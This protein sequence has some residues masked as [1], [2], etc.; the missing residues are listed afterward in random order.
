MLPSVRRRTKLLAPVAAVAPVLLTALPAHA[1]TT[2]VALWHMNSSPMVDATGHQANGTLTDVSVVSGGIAGSKA[3]SFTGSDSHVTVPNSATLNPGTSDFSYTMHLNFS[4]V[5]SKTVGDY[6]IIRKGLAGTSGGEWK[7]EI[8]P[9]TTTGAGNPFCLFKDSAGHTD[10]V[11]GNQ[12]LADGAWHTVTC[13]KTSTTDSL[14]VDGSTKSS[15]PSTPLG[16][17]SNTAPVVIGQ[18]WGGGDQYRGLLDE[19]SVTLGAASSGGVDTTPPTVTAKS[20]AAGSTGVSTATAVTARF[21]EAVQNVTGTTVKLK[22]S[23]TSTAVPAT[24]AY[25]SATDTATL[26]PKAA[27]NA[28]TKYT[29]TLTAG[30]KDLAGNA[31]KSLSWS[32]TTGSGT[33]TASGPTLTSRSPADGATGISRWTNVVATFD[34]PVRNVG[35]GTFTLAP[36]AGGPA[37]AAAYSTN[38]AKT[39]WV[40]NPSAGLAS[41]TRYTVTLVGGSS[42]ITDL[43]GNPLKS[44]TWSFT[45]G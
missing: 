17:I 40:L 23:G 5:P 36:A 14:T 4:V 12:D 9:N 37:V 6:D 34:E 33:T 15:T 27:L 32:F 29:A 39:R 8:L 10:T 11:R 30:I 16:S 44:T 13:T 38:S 1:A 43:Y 31:L 25:D 24:V 18:K 21:S 26:Q 22:V 20:P 7:M 19:A 42:G 35:S 3:Y 28:T 41:K 2:T 45:T